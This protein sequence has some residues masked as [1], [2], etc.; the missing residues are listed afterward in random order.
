MCLAQIPNSNCSHELSNETLK[1]YSFTPCGVRMANWIST[2]QGIIGIFINVGILFYEGF[3]ILSYCV[4]VNIS[5]T[6]I[7]SFCLVYNA[8][9]LPIGRILKTVKLGGKLCLLLNRSNKYWP[10]AASF[11]TSP[12]GFLSIFERVRS[13]KGLIE[14]PPI[15]SLEP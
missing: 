5:K 10:I 6:F 7:V 14:Y 11:I 3:I 2:K 1:F 9:R 12:F 8:R 15:C 13:I 4:C